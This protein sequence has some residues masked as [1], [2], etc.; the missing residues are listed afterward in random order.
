M[1]L[2]A[3]APTSADDLDALPKVHVHAHLDGSY[4]REA[5]RELA[6]RRGSAFA[7]PRSF[8]DVHDFFEAYGE[9]P[10]LV[11][12]LE[13]LAFL[14]TRLVEAETARGVVFLEPAIEPQLYAPRLGTLDEVTATIVGALQAAGEACGIDVGAN[15]TINTDQDDPVAMALAELA[16]AYAGRGVTALGTA[17]FIEPAGLGRYRELAE[18]ATAAGLQVVS[19]AGQ[20]GGPDSIFE[21]I[22]ELGAGRISHGVQ[23]VRSQALLARLATDRIVC[24]VCPVSNVRLGVSPSLAEHQAP[25]LV[26]AGVPVTLNADDEL[27][28]GQ[29]VTDQYR[30]A[31]DVWGWSR[32]QLA[33]IA[34]SGAL[35]PGARRGTRL[36]L[37]TQTG[38][39]ARTSN[40][41]VS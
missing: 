8:A 25:D 17:G 29:S 28:F 14:C 5:V 18:A 24:D 3:C 26:A 38:L 11:T 9:V 10:A 21:A 41:G 23:A 27:W 1:E 4:P 2:N 32:E 30:I 40:E 20:V 34:G 37:E 12:S 13:D 22:D 19:H 15:L 35:I 31:R 16:V 36:A 39:W 7:A 33:A 6:R